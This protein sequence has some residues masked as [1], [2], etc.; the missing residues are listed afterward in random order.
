MNPNEFGDIGLQQKFAGDDPVGAFLD[1][2]ERHDVT[3]TTLRVLKNRLYKNG[4]GNALQQFLARRG[5]TVP[6]ANVDDLFD[7]RDY[8]RNTA[9]MTDNEVQRRFSEASTM[10]QI[11]MLADVAS[12]NPAGFVLRRS[13]FD[14]EV[15]R[16]H[17]TL[18][19]MRE[20]L[21]WIPDPMFRVAALCYLK[22]GARR[23][24]VV[25]LDLCCL[26]IDDA[27]FRS[28][29]EARDVQVHDE[30]RGYPDSVY[31]YGG[32]TENERVNGEL[33]S[34]GTR[35]KNGTVIPLDREMKQAM[36]EWLTI[37][38]DTEESPHPVFTSLMPHDGQ[39]QR[40][41]VDSMYNRLI[42]DYTSDFDLKEPSDDLDDVDIH[43]FRHFFSTHMQIGRGDHDGSFE[44]PL[45]KFIRGDTLLDPV[46]RQY[47]HDNWGTNTKEIY[48]NN[49]YTFN[50]Y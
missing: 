4:N 39:F 29:L 36:M 46:L 9:E 23:S 44:F 50:L 48:V 26:S 16:D 45:I 34:H 38:P 14:L 42:R 33:R 27:R 11:F 28:Y 10:Y 47:T 24:E 18:Q 32:Y 20:F 1:F 31:I 40:I 8:L 30:L 7:Y 49:I 43:Y 15:E 21:D 5:V 22:W 3:E 17:V 19:Q 12:G 41:S 13:E 6:E 2:K 37:R 25:N 35:R